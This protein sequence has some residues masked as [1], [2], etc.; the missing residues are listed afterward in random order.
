MDTAEDRLRY[1]PGVA[2]T[3]AIFR[4]EPCRACRNPSRGLEYSILDQ[5]FVG[6]GITRDSLIRWRDGGHVGEPEVCP[7]CEGKGYSLAPIER[8][9][10]SGLA[11]VHGLVGDLVWTRWLAMPFWLGATLLCAAML[12]GFWAG[13]A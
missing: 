12:F 2:A 8:P 4:W 11:G 9:G 13:R 5:G 1:P 3:L 10:E 7:D 6:T